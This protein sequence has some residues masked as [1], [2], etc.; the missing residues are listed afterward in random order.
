MERSL[1]TALLASPA[2]WERAVT[3]VG[4]WAPGECWPGPVQG[5]PLHRVIPLYAG[6]API[7][8]GKGVLE[9]IKDLGSQQDLRMCFF[10]LSD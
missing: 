5:S 1:Q 4:G 7:S 6:A 9:G 2:A 3:T 10:L 8:R